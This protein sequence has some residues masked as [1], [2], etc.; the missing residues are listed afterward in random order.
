M[1]VSGAWSDSELVC[2]SSVLSLAVSDVNNC[3][4]YDINLRSVDNLKLPEQDLSAVSCD[5]YAHL[6]KLKDKLF[7]NTCCKP[8]ILI[9][10]DNYHLLLPLELSVGKPYEPVAT[11]T[12]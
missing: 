4:F 7:Y 6:R 5:E 12:P 3:N 10:Q 11:R 1:R 9:G 2:T 8:E